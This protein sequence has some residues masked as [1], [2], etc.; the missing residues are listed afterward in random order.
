M[1]LLQ[2]V[3]GT[4]TV[5]PPAP[6]APEPVASTGEDDGIGVVVP[7]R[8]EPVA[9][10]QIIEHTSPVMVDPS[11]LRCFYPRKKDRRSGNER[12]GTRLTFD[13]GAGMPVTNSFEEVTALY[14]DWLAENR[15][16]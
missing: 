11:K 5:M 8:S 9:Q 14:N 2:M 12:T 15:R 7:L 13:S 1:I 3:T 6:P 4:E 16:S 10:P